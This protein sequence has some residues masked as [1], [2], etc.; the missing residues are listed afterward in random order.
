MRRTFR[1]VDSFLNRRW[2]N[3]IRTFVVFTLVRRVTSRRTETE[4]NR[5]LIF[6]SETFD[7][8]FRDRSE[9]RSNCFCEEIYF[10]SRTSS[11]ICS[12]R[13]KRNVASLSVPYARSIL[14]VSLFPRP[15]VLPRYGYTSMYRKLTV[16]RT[17]DIAIAIC[18]RIWDTV[19]QLLRILL[20]STTTDEFRGKNSSFLK[21]LIVDQFLRFI[22]NRRNCTVFFKPCC[23]EE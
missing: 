8:R 5:S 16:V 22:V 19:L 7:T 3:Q 6:R 15:L 21:C 10:E 9:R 18:F 1:C 14:Y 2:R 11:L 23:I 4:V 17:S 13:A 12:T 20:V